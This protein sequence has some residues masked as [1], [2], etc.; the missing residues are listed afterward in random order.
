MD[1]KRTLIGV[2]VALIV[3]AVALTTAIIVSRDRAQEAEQSQAQ[4]A[5]GDYADGRPVIVSHLGV[6]QADDSLPTLTEFFDYTCHYCASMNAAV[7]E[8][9]AQK[10][11]AGQFNIAYQPVKTANMAMAR[12][13]TAAS[14][15][16]AQKDPEHWEAF[17][18][19]L[20]A[21]FGQEF[22]AGRATVIQDEAK[23]T[24]QVAKIAAEVGVPADVIESFSDTGVD[25][26]L[27]KSTQA[28]KD[29]NVSG[30]DASN[31]G[32]PEFVKDG[33]TIVNV[34]QDTPL[35]S[36]LS[37]MGLSAR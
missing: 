37:G 27:E 19:A 6:G 35:E 10:A 3:A 2:L 23:S 9:L 17:H 26:Y 16:V 14:L 21:Y 1:K 34:S 36:I 33:K 7:G 25:A 31:F 20:L 12:P 4:S 18:H 29:M 32:T 22:D 8:G 13:A 24:E 15:I 11:E 5:L 28:W 30:R